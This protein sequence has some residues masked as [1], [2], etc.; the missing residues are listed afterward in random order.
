MNNILKEFKKVPTFEEIANETLNPL[1][2]IPLPN[3]E[4][5]IARA[6]QLLTRYDD[7][8][9]LNLQKENANNNLEQL[10]QINK[11]KFSQGLKKQLNQIAITQTD[12][13]EEEEQQNELSDTIELFNREAEIERLNKIIE[14]SKQPFLSDEPLPDGINTSPE[15]RAAAASSSAARDEPEEEQATGSK[16]KRKKGRPKKQEQEQEE[17]QASGSKDKKKRGRQFKEPM[18]EPQ[19]DK[20]KYLTLGFLKPSL[21]IEKLKIALLKEAQDTM[22]NETTL[23]KEY[24]EI[25]TRFYS[26]EINRSELNDA[27]VDIRAQKINELIETNKDFKPPAKYK[28]TKTYDPNKKKKNEQ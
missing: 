12:A 3:R 28:R 1:Y 22:L 18:D 7:P 20:D 25:F 26:K 19:P 14:E 23:I 10:A 4:Y 15:G 27:I 11:N 5:S 9:F 17:E 13:D 21:A 8:D 6:N 2:K 24:E 16:D